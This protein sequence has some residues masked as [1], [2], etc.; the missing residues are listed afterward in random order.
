[1]Q[2]GQA[3]Y[4]AIAYGVG[5]A[6]GSLGAGYLWQHVSPEAVFVVAGAAA[7]LGWWIAWRKVGEP[8][9]SR[10]SAASGRD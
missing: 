10:V 3:V 2:R 8:G 1:M 5:G 4:N 6:V 7:L 9:V